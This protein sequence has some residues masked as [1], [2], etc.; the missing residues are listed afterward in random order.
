MKG[1][2]VNIGQA[3]RAL[4]ELATRESEALLPEGITVVHYDALEA[5]SQ[6]MDA[7]SG[8]MSA[9]RVGRVV[10]RSNSGAASL[11]EELMHSGHVYRS[12]GGSHILT[13][14][15]SDL[16]EGCRRA[17]AP[18]NEGMASMLKE[19]GVERVAEAFVELL[20][21]ARWT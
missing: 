2:E 8:R 21:D 18:I 19:D 6:W 14:A 5:I 1:I 15:G 12:S 20:A 16:L 9:A 4:A 10:G 7:P 11:M 17:L 3:L 13:Q